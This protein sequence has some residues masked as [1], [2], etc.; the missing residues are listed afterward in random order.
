MRIGRDRPSIWLDVN[1]RDNN[2]N[3]SSNNSN[4]SR[5]N[6]SNNTDSSND[7]CNNNNNKNNNNNNKPFARKSAL[8]FSCHLSKQLYVG[9]SFGCQRDGGRSKAGA[10]A[11]AVPSPRTPERRNGPCRVYAPLCSTETDDGKGQGG[12]ERDAQ[13]HGPDDSSPQG[14]KHGVLQD[15]R[16]R[17]RACRPADTSRLGAATAGV[18]RHTGAHIVDFSPFVQILD[19]PVPQM[20]G[21]QVVEFM[22]KLVAPAMDEQVIAVPKISLDRVPKRCPRPRTHRVDQLV[23]VPTITSYSS[24]QQ[25]NVEQIIDIPVPHDRGDRGG[26]GGLQGFSRGQGTTAFRGAEFVDIPVSQGRGGL[27]GGGLQSFSQEQ[28]S[29]AFHGADH[30]GFPVPHGRV[31]VRGLQGFLSGQGSAASSSHVGSAEAAGYGVFRTFPRLKKSAGYGPHSGSE[32]GA[33]FTPWTPAANAESM[34]GAYDVAVEESEAAVVVEEGAETRF[35]AG[36]QPMRVC[37]RFLEHQLGR[38]VRGCACGDRCTFAH[39]WAEL[40]PQASAHEQQ[41]ASHFPD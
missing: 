39:S 10:T 20:R 21:E 41:L 8:C 2:R 22:R 7:S 37:T 33:D 19:D 38:P 30:A 18:L 5:N 17:G 4:D 9:G 26:G 35:A 31:G 6:S 12:G 23:E 13:R 28:G 32:L 29:T 15:G 36:F 14:G 11:Q 24:L 1:S 3:D 40:H 25:R 27:G 16:R 34:E